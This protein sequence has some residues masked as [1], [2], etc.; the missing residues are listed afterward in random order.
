[1][2]EVQFAGAWELKILTSKKVDFLLLSQ[3][4]WALMSSLAPSSV[5]VLLRGNLTPVNSWRM[6]STQMFG[7]TSVRS[8]AV[9]SLIALCR[10]EGMAPFGQ[11]NAWLTLNGW[12]HGQCV[13]S[14]AGVQLNL[15]QRAS[16]KACL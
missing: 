10:M 7:H 14:L 11:L 13:A 16:L 9:M 2:E 1:M 12:P 6:G 4:F 3:K 5:L 8:C 15:R